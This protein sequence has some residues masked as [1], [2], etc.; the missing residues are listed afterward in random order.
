MD[1]P[2]FVCDVMLGSLARWLRFAGF[3]TRDGAGV[4]AP[5]LGAQARAEGRWLLTRDRSMASSAGPRVLLIRAKN[6]AGQ[7]AELRAR[8]GVC[9]RPE[10]FF[11]RCSECNGMLVET[12]RR[13]VA[14]RVPPYVEAHAERFRGC[15]E[16]GRVYWAGSHVGRIAARLTELFPRSPTG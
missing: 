10:L 15:T 3:D 5:A 16:C 4:R 14:G 6:L 12:D 13:S 9:G 7:V 1:E 8:L 11:T 2:R